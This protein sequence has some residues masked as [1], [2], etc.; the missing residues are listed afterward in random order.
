MNFWSF[1]AGGM[2]V[3][4]AEIALMFGW[5]LWESRTWGTPGKSSRPF[6]RRKW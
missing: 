4:L 1:I 2:T 5:L 6:V 3:V